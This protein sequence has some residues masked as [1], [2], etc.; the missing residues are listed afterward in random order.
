MKSATTPKKRLSW[1]LRHALRSQAALTR[2]RLRKVKAAAAV[3]KGD[4]EQLQ[5]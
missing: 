3:V 1:A 5:V 2:S 4:N